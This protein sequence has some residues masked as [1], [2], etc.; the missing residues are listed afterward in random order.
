MFPKFVCSPEK[1]SSIVF[2]PSSFVTIL[3]FIVFRPSLYK[4]FAD[5]IFIFS[6]SLGS[7]ILIVGFLYKSYSLLFV[8]KVAV[9]C[10]PLFVSNV[11]KLLLLISNFAIVLVSFNNVSVF[12]I[13]SSLLLTT[14]IVPV[15]LFKVFKV[16][17]S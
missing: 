11:D 13:S 2:T 4:T 14:F 1:A 8:T 6:I 15:N 10:T 3:F 16:C 9:I 5:V 17:L 7:S 12:I